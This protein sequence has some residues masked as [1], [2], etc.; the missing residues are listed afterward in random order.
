MTKA[1]ALIEQQQQGKENTAIWMV[2]EQL[3]EICE[4]EPA[5]AELVEKDME[6]GGLTLAGAE[7]K[8]KAKAD[9]IRKTVKGNCV[10]IAPNVA[11]GIIREYFGLPERNDKTVAAQPAEAMGFSLEDLL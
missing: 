9:E 8:I 2:G 11:E 6:S 4:K 7:A 5:C 3:K 10:C 1:N